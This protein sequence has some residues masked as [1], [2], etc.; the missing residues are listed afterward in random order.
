MKEKTLNEIGLLYNSD[1]VSEHHNY[2]DLYDKYFKKTRFDSNEILEIGVLNG[3]SVKMLRDYFENSIITGVDIEDKRHLISD[4][5]KILQGDQSNRT[6]L[7]SFDDDFYDIIIDDGSHKMEH[8]QLSF[9]VLFKKLK[10][11]GIYVIEDLHTSLPEYFET[12]RYGKSL[13]G[14]NE[15]CSNSTI[16]FLNSIKTNNPTSAYLTEDELKYI[17]NNTNS[18]EVFVTN[19]KHNDKQS[20]TSIIIKN[21]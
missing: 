3:D 15:D 20:I 2:L 13:F 12:V 14:L 18:V 9:G 17:S 5:I 16:N 19:N 1:K 11:G 7:N 6:F 21:D 4:R 10:K 8:Q